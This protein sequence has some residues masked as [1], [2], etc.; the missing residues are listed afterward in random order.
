MLLKKE[1][2]THKDHQPSLIPPHLKSEVEWFVIAGILTFPL[3]AIGAILAF[4]L[5]FLS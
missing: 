2:T 5:T 4:L 3:I 1:A